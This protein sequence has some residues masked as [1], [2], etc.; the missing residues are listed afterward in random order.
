MRS[1]YFQE[2]QKVRQLWIYMLLVLVFALWMW[3]LIQQVVMGV[4]FGTDPAPNW[5]ILFIGLIPI[6]AT[7]L[8]ALLKLETRVSS[9]SMEY[10]MW[11][12]HKNY[13][14]L[15]A[16]EIVHFE[17]KKYNPLLDYGGWGIRQGFGRK[18]TAYNM[19]GNMGAL[20]E[21]KSGKKIMIG[22]RKPEELRSALNRMM[23]SVPPE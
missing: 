8:I 14:I 10:R 11:P 6:G 18:G 15:Q 16:N 3:Q 5:A 20:V 2:T 13:R 22:T 7:V 23:K 19:S 1:Y 17:V 9:E 21:L 4:P 12:I